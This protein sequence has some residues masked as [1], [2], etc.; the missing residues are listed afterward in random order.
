M[1]KLSNIE[2]DHNNRGLSKK[3]ISNNNSH[4]NNQLNS[5]T[6][7]QTNHRV[8]HRHLNNDHADVGNQITRNSK[9]SNRRNSDD[10]YDRK[11]IS[12]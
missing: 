11:M 8:H 12:Y 9:N 1:T 4:S 3:I 7:M 5:E 10:A 6:R 2:E